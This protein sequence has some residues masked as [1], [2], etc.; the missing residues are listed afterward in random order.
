L[1]AERTRQQGRPTAY[2]CR[3]L[4]CRLPVTDPDAL[5]DQLDDVAK[6]V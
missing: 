3:Q 4:A 6:A 2:V 1:L 5:R